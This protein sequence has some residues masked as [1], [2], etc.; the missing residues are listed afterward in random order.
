[1]K[2]HNLQN[3]TRG[4]VVGNFENN[5]Y[6]KDYELG[7]KYYKAGDY[8]KAHYHLMSDEITIILS[9]VVEIN[10]VRYGQGMIITQ[11]KGEASDFRCIEDA[12]TAVYRSDA[13][14][15]NDKYFKKEE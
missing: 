14:V 12:I 5:L 6:K 10:N 9:G 2:L 7:F 15:P 8:E 4:W 3:F 11:E 13:S 1:M